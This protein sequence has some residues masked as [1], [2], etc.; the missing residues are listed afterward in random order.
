M[1]NNIINI[2]VYFSMLGCDGAAMWNMHGEDASKEWTCWNRW[3]VF[4]GERNHL[5]WYCCRGDLLDR[6]WNMARFVLRIWQ[7]PI[8]AGFGKG[9]VR[10]AFYKRMALW[11]RDVRTLMFINLLLT[12]ILE[13]QGT[14]L[15]PFWG[16]HKKIRLFPINLW[17][18]S[19][20]TDT[21]NI[22]FL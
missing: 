4:L 13:A 2:W 8:Y 10:R 12:K 15:K 21:S 19:I 17:I 6:S 18:E 1:L 3:Q 7:R 16:Y 9:M 20:L 5:V 14:G 22:F 11:L